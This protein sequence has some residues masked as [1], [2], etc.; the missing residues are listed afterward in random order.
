MSKLEHILYKIQVDTDDSYFKLTDEKKKDFVSFLWEEM[1]GNEYY[2][3][4]VKPGFLTPLD[5]EW[6][7]I[8]KL[9]YLKE[10]FL[11]QEKYEETQITQDL[12]DITQHKLNQVRNYAERKT[13]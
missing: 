13:K 4:L 3:S 5:I 1:Y 9:N 10:H 12:L 11:K 6:D 8:N 2:R 7:I